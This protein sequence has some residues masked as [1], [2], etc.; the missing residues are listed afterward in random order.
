MAYSVQIYKA[1]F[2]KDPVGIFGTLAEQKNIQHDSVKITRVNFV[3]GTNLVQ[4]SL[5]VD[6][7]SGTYRCDATINQPTNLLLIQAPRPT[8]SKIKTFIAQILEKQNS[9]NIIKDIDLDISQSLKLFELITNENESNIIEVLTFYFEYELGFKY[10]KEIYTEISYKF[11]Q[12]R[13]ASEHK[14]FHQLCKNGKRCTMKFVVAKCRDL[15]TDKSIKLIAKPDSSFRTYK[16]IEQD[17]WD[18]F[19]FNIGYVNDN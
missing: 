9:G 2:S 6:L 1:Y 14:D 12:N 18:D 16:N 13:C 5:N 3:K 4:F 11:V 15:V 8:R 17:V 7:S 19:C 10:E